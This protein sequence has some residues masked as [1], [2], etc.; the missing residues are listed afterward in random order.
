MRM[1]FVR[2]NWDTEVIDGKY[3]KLKQ[4]EFNYCWSPQHAVNMHL[5]ERY[6]VVQ[7]TKTHAPSPLLPLPAIPHL[8]VHNELVAREVLMRIYYAQFAYHL[9]HK[10]LAPSLKVLLSNPQMF[11]SYL[12]HDVHQALTQEWLEHPLLHVPPEMTV[13]DESSTPQE[14]LV[15]FIAS[16][17]VPSDTVMGSFEIW[18]IRKDGR[19]ACTQEQREWTMKMNYTLPLSDSNV[20]HYSA[21]FTL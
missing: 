5:P 13:Y 21:P 14:I 15:G 11:V 6:G 9:K 4:S 19:I 16:L 2:V 1:N 12:P 18:H 7:F 8:Q 20:F 3:C 10:R 17:A